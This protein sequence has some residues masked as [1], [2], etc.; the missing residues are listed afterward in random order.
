MVFLCFSSNER[1]SAA[2]SCLYHLKN[3]GIKTWYDYHQLILGDD[4]NKKNFEVAIK[5][6]N[7]FIIIYSKAFF[8]SR[9]AV[10]EETLIFKEAQ[11]RNI[12]IFPLLY[13]ISFSEL[14]LEYKTKIDKLIYNEIS[15]KTGT[16]APINQIISKILIN[17]LGLDSL[18]LTPEINENIISQINE[19]YLKK[20]L[21]EYLNISYQNFNARIAILFCVFSYI[22]ENNLINDV[23]YYLGKIISYLIT[24]THLDIQ[25]NHKE[26]I[27]AELVIIHCLNLIG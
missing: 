9:C 23:P 16:I 26:L 6:C 5:E 22:K 18:E 8:Q 21:I 10:E 14:P 27:I 19:P 17:N 12:T 25:Y 20:I 2:K 4:K 11:K 3:Y 24:F 15:D 13:N 7:Y 1:Y